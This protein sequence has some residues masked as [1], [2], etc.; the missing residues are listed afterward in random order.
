M[1]DEYNVIQITNDKQI[2]AKEYGK[3]QKQE[4]SSQD[5]NKLPEGD[6]NEKYVGKTIGKKT[7]LNVSYTKNVPSHGSETIITSSASATSI[8]STASSVVAVA[9]TV[10]VTAVAV[11]TGISVVL[12]DYEY[13]FNSFIVTSDSLTYELVIIDNK[14]EEKYDYEYELQ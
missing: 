14:S 2:N 1:R 11:A 8:A 13:K 4:F 7:E 12:H 5:E 9:S 3:T 6:L 10:A